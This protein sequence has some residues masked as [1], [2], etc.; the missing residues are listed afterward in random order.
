MIKVRSPQDLGAGIL[1]LLFGLAGI[2]LGRD[3]DFG[4]ARNMGPGY[5]PILISCFIVVI[6]AIVAGRAFLVEGP[7]IE[8]VQFRPIFMLLVALAVFGFL[9]SQ[10]GVVL[11]SIL[12]MI[13]AAYARPHVR[14]VETLIFAVC[15]AI[16]VAVVFVFGLN[17][18]MP[19]W[20]NG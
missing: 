4:S 10:I 11:T 3:L 2:F 9:I 19:L 15:V 16:F 18:P 6:G 5:F 14:I 8:R 17:Q 20:W 1:F 7:A 12:M 13:V